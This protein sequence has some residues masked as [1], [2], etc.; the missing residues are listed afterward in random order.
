MLCHDCSVPQGGE[1]SGKIEQHPY[2]RSID[3]GAAK[4]GFFWPEAMRKSEGILS[5]VRFAA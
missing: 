5:V 3:R 4:P 1:N 2:D